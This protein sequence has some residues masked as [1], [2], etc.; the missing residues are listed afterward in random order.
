MSKD[1]SPQA[2]EFTSEVIDIQTKWHPLGRLGKAE[3]M[4][5]LVVFLA[6]DAASFITG[7]AIAV[8]GGYPRL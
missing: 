7:E 8:S 1:T 5:N 4:A 2:N 6:S 3:D